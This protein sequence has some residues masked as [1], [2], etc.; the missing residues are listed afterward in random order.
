M[1]C[2]DSAARTGADAKTRSI[3][4]LSSFFTRALATDFIPFGP[5]AL[6]P[7][8]EARAASV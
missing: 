5:S 8:C 3:P 1:E 4:A 2:F 6:C 7:H